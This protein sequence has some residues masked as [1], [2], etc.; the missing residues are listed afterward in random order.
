MEKFLIIFRTWKKC[1]TLSQGWDA[2]S[3][4]FSLETVKAF[5]GA[6]YWLLMHKKSSKISDFF[7]SL[8]LNSHKSMIERI[9]PE[10]ILFLLGCAICSSVCVC[11]YIDIDIHSLQWFVEGLNSYWIP[12]FLVHFDL[13][14]YCYLS[15]VT[16]LFLIARLNEMFGIHFY[17]N[18]INSLKY[19]RSESKNT[20]LL[21]IKDNASMGL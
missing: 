21:H 8:L 2:V 11:V 18:Y 4:H 20:S 17:M 3:I 15:E 6:T 1:R 10:Q 12:C 19:V 13:L 5:Y 14:W 9:L 7:F 16:M